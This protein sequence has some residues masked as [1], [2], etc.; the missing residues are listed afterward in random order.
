MREEQRKL[1]IRDQL[2]ISCFWLAYNFQWGAL[3][4]IVLPSQIA[5]L[6]GD[7]R[8][9][10]FNG[11]IPAIGAALSLLATPIAGALSDRSTNRWGRRRPFM[12]TGTAI[13]ILF[14][15]LLPLFVAG[16]S[17]WLFVLCYLGVQFGNN[18]S[19]GPYAGLVPDVVPAEQRGEA[20]GWLALMTAIGYLFGA[21]AAGQ[22]AREGQYWG[23]YI[24]CAVV[25][26][27]FL[28]I[29][30]VGVRE[31]PLRVDPAPL[32]MRE[33]LGSF[34]LPWN[35]YRDFYFVLITRAMVMMGINSVLLYLQYFLRD[36]IRVE[37][38]EL[39]TGYL[40]AVIVAAG[41][42]TSVIAGKLSDRHGRKPLVYVSGTAMA[43]ASIIFIVNGFHPSLTFTYWIGAFFGI[44]F[45]AYQAVDWAL[46]I[47]V[48]PK[49]ESAAKDMG[50][51]HIALVLP[52]MLSPAL[53]G[54]ILTLFKS[55]SLLLGYA[56]V[57][58]VTAVWFI[59][60]T[61]LVRYIRGVR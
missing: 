59:L 25:L 32:R 24:A 11:I 46:A 60:G 13:N 38:P 36:I 26:A 42:P 27:V 8:K 23:I 43:I 34:I 58:A 6:V 61:V 14:I 2:A 16:S 45:G 29:T 4:A 35:E 22:L 21:F 28:A 48:L 37:N 1:T 41:L 47:D 19:G 56:I 50:I 18:W 15:L 3:M 33:F 54:G 5:L 55:Q 39:Q 30:A 53:T 7:E 57:F 17:L 40:V 12:V 10:F 31:E 20:S 52:Q 9:E 51:W 49:G 44:G